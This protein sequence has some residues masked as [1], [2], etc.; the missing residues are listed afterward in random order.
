VDG[1]FVFGC[2]VA[3]HG[4]IDWTN[5]FDSSVQTCLSEFNISNDENNKIAVVGGKA[6]HE[7][8]SIRSFDLPVAHVQAVCV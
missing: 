3:I 5:N 6:T 4:N 2:S 8:R 1:I 7:N